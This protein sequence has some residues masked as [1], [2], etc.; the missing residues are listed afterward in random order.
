MSEAHGEIVETP[1]AQL[2]YKAAITHDAKI[3]REQY[4]ATRGEAEV[5][6]VETL[7]GLRGH[8]HVEGDPKGT[9]SR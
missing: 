7:E 2:P 5:Y 9:G 6:I 1:T 3:I 8:V 4:F